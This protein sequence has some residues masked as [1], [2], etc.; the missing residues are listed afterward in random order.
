MQRSPV[1]IA[2]ILTALMG[3]A[4]LL[5]SAAVPIVLVFL[6]TRRPGVRA[7]VIAVVASPICMYIL[8]VLI[9]ELFYGGSGGR[10]LNTRVFTEF[11]IGTS[12]LLFFVGFWA[13]GTRLL[14]RRG[15]R[16]CATSAASRS[17]N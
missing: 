14:M 4:G 5:T 3:L 17:T 6:I 10:G 2:D 8:G 15:A 16:S 7:F 13:L 9:S 12:L 11:F 1:S